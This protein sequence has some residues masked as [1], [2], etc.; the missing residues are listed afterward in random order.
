MSGPVPLNEYDD[1]AVERITHFVEK[2]TGGKVVGLERLVRWRPSWFADVAID[3]AVARLH[4]RGD[5][6]G[7]VSIFPDL[8]READVID[9]LHQHG[10]PV[11]QIHGYL[12]DPPCIV[13]EA[14][15]GTR[16]FSALDETTKSAI[17]R[18]YMHAIA[19][20]HRL[21]I[22]PFVAAGLHRP[23]GAEAIALAGLD[24]YMPHYQRTKSRPEPLLAFVI[25][26]LR[27]NVPRHRTQAS[28]IQF[29]SGQ[30]LVDQGAMT[31][32]YDFEFSMIGDPLVD[33][34]TMGMRNSYEPL[35][36]PL[37]ELVR[38][39]EEATG[40]PVDHDVVLFHVLQ[41]S[42]LGTM[43]FAGTVGVP[44][45]GDPHSVYLMF[46]LALRRSILL[47][48]S[49]LSGVALPDLP[50]LAEQRGDN[51]PL[52][53]KIADTLAGVPVSDEGAQMQKAQVAELIEWAQRADAHGAD[54]V[55]RN[56][57]DVSALLGE[58]FDGWDAAAAA[59]EGYASA[60]EPDQDAALIRL[61]GTIEGRRLQLFGPTALG[62]AA[63]HVVLPATR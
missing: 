14:I 41:F 53:A 36:A 6:G 56:I 40:E 28:F 7:D 8:K 29:D 57:A 11:P 47:A 59:L 55:A 19:A 35:G 10:L 26:W 23:E 13:M 42:L 22:E 48:L 38:Y 43:Q 45:P 1:A 24:A 21:P 62:A 16:D 63:S 15:A 49:A 32:L 25:G 34:A 2:L 37:P 30:Y 5:R 33:I 46:D 12:A 4:L 61:L 9:I 50:P 18:D 54:M 44:K 58:S 17:G 20:M 31:K 27:R 60:V 52:M 39:Y 51:C 3:G